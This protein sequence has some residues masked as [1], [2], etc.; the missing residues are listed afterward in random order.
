MR[1]LKTANGIFLELNSDEDQIKARVE[2]YKLILEQENI[3]LTENLISEIQTKAKDD[4]K[5]MTDAET[6]KG[7]PGIFNEL[8]TKNKKNEIEAFFR[9]KSITSN[10]LAL[11][12][13]NHNQ[14]GFSHKSIFKQYRPEQLKIKPEEKL[15]IPLNTAEGQKVRRKM[16]TMFEQRKHVHA[17]FFQKETI[18]YCFFWDFKD[19][20]G[21]PFNN[22][23][24][25]GS[26]IHFVSS[27][28]GLKLDDVLDQFQEKKISLPK[29]HIKFELDE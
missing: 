26:H 9:N 13:M 27:H 3:P 22:H 25:N 1:T 15:L 23:W 5:K 8:F 4:H 2:I 21:K 24:S 12:I 11:F 17:H 6:K 7:I 16:I 29:L 28:W 14:I 10:D 18:W 19:I 20:Q